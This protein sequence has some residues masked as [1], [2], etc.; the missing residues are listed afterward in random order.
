MTSNER[1]ELEMK[2]RRIEL[3]YVLSQKKCTDRGASGKSP[4]MSLI[5]SQNEART[6][7]L[8]QPMELLQSLAI[9]AKKEQQATR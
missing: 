2:P 7:Y 6:N 9:A 1:G 3:P 4:R 8:I 5:T